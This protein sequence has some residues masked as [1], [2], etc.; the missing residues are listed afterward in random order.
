MWVKRFYKDKNIKFGRPEWAYAREIS[1]FD[2]Q[3]QQT[4]SFTRLLLTVLDHVYLYETS[5]SIEIR[6]L[7][8]WQL[9]TEKMKVIH[10]SG[11]KNLTLF[12][13]FA[14]GI[15]PI[16]K[17]FYCDANQIKLIFQQPYSCEFNC[18]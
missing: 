8:V 2:D 9:I 10:A 5:F 4:K 14:T 12:D 13:A 15:R 17:R 18:Q 6:P 7:K 3:E 16:F 11:P 1:Q